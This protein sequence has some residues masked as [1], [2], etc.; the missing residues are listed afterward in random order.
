MLGEHDD[1]VA[2]A[3]PL[4]GPTVSWARD[5]AREL[6]VDLVAGSIVER[7]DGHEKLGNTS[8]TSAPTAR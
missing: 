7:R 6:G 1:Y 2:G 3:E 8:S 4:D 5:I